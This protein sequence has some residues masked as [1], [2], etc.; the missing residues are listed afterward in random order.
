[1]LSIIGG[2]QPSKL[3]RIVK[4]VKNDTSNDGFLQRF[5]GVTFPNKK[6]RFTV[7]PIDETVKP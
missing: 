3:E 5:Q 1:M 6:L 2:T 4:E 7:D